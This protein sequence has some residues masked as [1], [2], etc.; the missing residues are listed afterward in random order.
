[1][2]MWP[3]DAAS[4]NQLGP[5]FNAPSVHGAPLSAQEVTITAYCSVA[6]FTVNYAAPK[7]PHIY[8]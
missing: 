8:H 4:C 1:P 5:V 7:L 6:I 2:L 3:L